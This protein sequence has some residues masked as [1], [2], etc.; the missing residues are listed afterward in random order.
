MI[1]EATA[2]GVGAQGGASSWDGWFAP[3]FR[4]IY[5]HPNIKMFTYLNDN[6]LDSPW[7]SW[8]N[9]SI[10]EHSVVA[11]NMQDELENPV[12]LGTPG[13]RVASTNLLGICGNISSIQTTSAPKP[14]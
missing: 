4:Y 2:V 8:G 9:C 10:P 11:E 13:D 12:L 7:P 5:S 1:G 6:F 3:Y 14:I